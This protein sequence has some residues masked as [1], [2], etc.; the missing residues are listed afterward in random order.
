MN[1]SPFVP[2]TTATE[3]P[4]VVR[5]RIERPRLIAALSHSD[6]RLVVIKAP[7][8]YGKTTLAVDWS[9]EA[10]RRGQ[11]VSWIRAEAEYNDLRTFLYYLTRAVEICCSE[12]ARVAQD[13][14]QE[15]RPA[16]AY[17]VVSALANGIAESGDEGCLFIDDYH[18]LESDEVRDAILFFYRHT[19]SHFRLVITTREEPGLPLAY[20][21]ASAELLVLDVDQLRFSIEEAER[22]FRRESTDDLSDSFI[23]SFQHESGGWAAAMRI[24]SVSLRSGVLPD[25]VLRA[26]RSGARDIDSY[27][28]NTLTRLPLTVLDFMEKSSI[29]K[30][31]TPEACNSTLAIDN[32]KEVLELLHHRYQLLQPEKQ[33]DDVYSYHPLIGKHLERRL[34]RR[35]G[36]HVIQMLHRRAALWFGAH[37]QHVEAIKHA[38]HAGEHALAAE[39]VEACAMRM[40]Q[41]GDIR[42]VLGCTRW[43]SKPLMRNQFSLR[44][45]IGWSLALAPQRS[46]VFAWINE[47]ETDIS[48]DP[49]E[50][51]TLNECR[52]IRTVALGL[53]DEPETALQC[54]IE[55]VDNPHLDPWA[56]SAVGN[57]I[58]YC[59]L[60][61]ARHDLIDRA[62]K[63]S[64]ESNCEL[65]PAPVEIYRLGI[66]GLSLAQRLDFSKAQACF[67]QASVIAEKH[68]RPSS[69]LAVTPTVFLAHLAYEGNH[70]AAAERLIC[71]RLHAIN[72]SGF[73]EVPLSAYQT[74]T[75]VALQNKDHDLAHQLLNQGEA[76]ALSERWPRMQAALLVERIKL[77]IDVG[78]PWIVSNALVTL[79]VL[80]RQAATREQAIQDRLRA[81]LAIGIA[82][83]RM[84]EGN[85]AA[86]FS[87]LEPVWR[88]AD[89]G[90]CGN[91]YFACTIATL[92]S[93]ADFH[94]GERVR[95]CQR[96]LRVLNWASEGPLLRTI[97]DYSFAVE[98]LLVC[99]RER[100]ISTSTKARLGTYVAQLLALT[101][102]RLE[103]NRG[104]QTSTALVEN[105]L[106]PRETEVL[107]LLETG[108][109]N[110]RIAAT[111]GVSP[112][113]VKTYI[114]IIFI[115]LDV[116]SRIR[117]VVEARRLKL[118][119]T[120]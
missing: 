68:L 89:T 3:C 16:S 102:S 70:I 52:A 105:P 97:V 111:L 47:I 85:F 101:H 44:L 27:L 99:A 51:E 50:A 120:E 25:E 74:L 92:L 36:S 8:G 69:S 56:K 103:D 96:F 90:S 5:S 113:T 18:Y 48:G 33:H 66:M 22:F 73:L 115:K 79:E 76:I 41:A 12:A 80:L 28:E 82:Y 30:S 14:L 67:L 87:A 21:R 61:T 88:A 2:L 77:G 15:R 110:K 57:A 65:R 1:E 78:D 81:Y 38:I 106:S 6:A 64:V 109:S 32:A 10:V 117:A 59:H 119:A 39:W 13:M 62:S 35:A 60:I 83:V 93:V 31:L 43:L 46:E 40:I 86:A 108:G 37:G 63:E 7:A 24:A 58:R 9:I 75:R 100:L 98:P 49:R 84:H 94:C 55:H 118:L 104:A 114:K 17:A 107:Q 23:Q 29:L 54:G 112:E 26:I 95:A 45:A 53:S 91:R 11:A 71:D 19:P 4:P 72:A 34:Q 20:L 42:E 116:D